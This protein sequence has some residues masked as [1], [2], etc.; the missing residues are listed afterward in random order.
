M[1]VS[2]DE[3]LDMLKE[4]PEVTQGHGSEWISLKVHGKGF[5]YLWERTETVGLKATIEEQ[6]ALVGERPDVFEI[7]FTAGRFGW[8]VVHLTKIDR[9]E[10]M[11]LVTEAWRLT[12]PKRLLEAHGF[13]DSI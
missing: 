5:G 9:E 13:D 7:Q 2:V 10:L 6:M 4:L 11:E 1:G 3:F 12:A 8:V